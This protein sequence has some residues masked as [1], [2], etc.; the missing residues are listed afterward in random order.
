MSS[1]INREAELETLN[2]EYSS[3]SSSLMIIYGRRRVGK[4]TL[5]SE[6]INGKKAMYF[7][8]DKE[9]E[10]ES[11]KRFASALAD[12]TGDEYLKSAS[13]GNWRAI[14]VSK[15]GRWWNGKEEIDIV[16]IGGKQ[17]VFAECKF[18]NKPMDVDVYYGLM[19]K[20]ELVEWNK[21]SRLKKSRFSP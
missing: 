3:K 19:Q 18:R 11:M 21:N 8:A 16:G 14:D 9:T 17:I 7:L 4:T 6:F 5:I 10:K 1:F 20:K 15:I 2:N 13:F 12:Y